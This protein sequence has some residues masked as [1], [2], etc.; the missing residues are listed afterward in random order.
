MGSE[1]IRKQKQKGS[2][3]RVLQ[4]IIMKTS[5]KTI[6]YLSVLAIMDAIIPIPFTTL[7]LIYVV[8]EKPQWFKNLF[9]DIYNP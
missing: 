2:R 7:M 9:N 5:T 4:G 3:S 6:I 8:L 1:K